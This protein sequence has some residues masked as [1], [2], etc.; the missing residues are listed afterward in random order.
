MDF[1][2]LVPF[3]ILVV[4]GTL[5]VIGVIVSMLAERKRREAVRHVADEMGLA[6]HENGDPDLAERLSVLPLFAKGVGKRTA[7]MICGDTE[8]MLMG[9]CDYRYT[10][11]GGKN[12]HTYNQSI[13]FFQAPD[14]HLPL[15]E[16]RP[17]SFFHGLGRIF[18]QKGIDFEAHPRFSKN[19]LV[20][21]PDEERLRALF[22]FELLTALEQ[23]EEICLQGRNQD[24]VFF[25][26]A[27]L[28][29]PRE[30]KELMREGFEFFQ[31][32]R[33]E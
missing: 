18:G 19:Y 11:G 9:V 29:E 4:V 17:R 25:R 16:L 2:I 5:M 33:R 24:F 20:L 28:V 31:M 14:L 32:L 21:G 22:D 27:T 10:V 12:S 7:N 23:K 13:A 6:F 15:F 1:D 30:L 8:E 3:L 26:H